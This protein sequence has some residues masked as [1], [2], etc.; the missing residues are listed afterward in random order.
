MKP[1]HQPANTPVT[2]PT[3]TPAALL[4]AAALYLQQHGWTQH[5]FY[6]LV[7]ITDGQ[8]PPACASGAIMTAAT[9]RCLA[10]G[11]CTLDGD[12]D[13]IA[14]IRALRVFAAWLDLEYTPTGFYETSAIDVVG[15][16]N[17][18]EGRTRDEVIETLT[19]AADDWDRLH[20]TGGAR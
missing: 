15:D 8:F 13:T 1:T 14:A 11:V 10:S 20:H 5:Q 3:M 16:W 12:P 4:R 7:A 6:D 2:D 19:D 9:G 18:Y 17:D